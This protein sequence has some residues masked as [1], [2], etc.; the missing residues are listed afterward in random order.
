MMWEAAKAALGGVNMDRG[1]LLLVSR[2]RRICVWPQ[3]SIY[4]QWCRTVMLLRPTEVP[5]KFL[6]CIGWMRDSFTQL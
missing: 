4:S 1:R 2:L 3:N 6:E 5:R